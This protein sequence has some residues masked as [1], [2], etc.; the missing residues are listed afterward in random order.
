MGGITKHP[1]PALAILASL[2]TGIGIIV[3]TAGHGTLGN[4][5]SVYWRVANLPVELAYSPVPEFPF[6][7][8]PTMLLWI[9]PL[10]L[11]KF[12]PALAAWMI[13]S[14]FC[15]FWACRTHLSARE[16]LLVFVSPVILDCLLT[17]QVSMVLAAMLLI[18]MGAPNRMAGGVLLGAIATVKPQLVALAPIL[19]LLR[20]D[21]GAFGAAAVSF[22]LIVVLA[23]VVYGMQ[24]WIDWAASLDHFRTVL[25]DKD[26]ISGGLTPASLAE[27][28]GF[29]AVPVMI[30]GACVALWL[31]WRCRNLDA[32][33]QCAV[34]T[35][36][37]L[38]AAP[39]ALVYDFVG[40]LPFLA[41]A[42]WRGR[43]GAA[44]ALA[45]ILPPAPVLIAAW[46]LDRAAA[47]RDAPVAKVE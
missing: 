47:A 14:L 28:W 20:R 23:V 44:L 12:G 40:I 36:G 6:P 31:I 41:V 19:L 8:A 10:S 34:V 11:V 16:M 38:L 2:L 32:V 7:Y 15:L 18:A 45:E 27:R 5:F 9:A 29:S 39:Y 42:I 13:I 1:A 33:G 26:I 25:H 37:S 21:W 46:E 3:L 4:D 22:A 30:I 43:F 17:G 35:C 24:P